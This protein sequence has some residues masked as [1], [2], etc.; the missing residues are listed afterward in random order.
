MEW[1]HV[2]RTGHLSAR[3]IE[4][5]ILGD[6]H[7]NVIHLGERDCSL[8]RNNQ[9]VLEESPSIAIGKRC[10]MKSVLLLFERQSLLAMRMQGPF[11]FL[12]DE[13]SGKF[14]FMEIIHVFR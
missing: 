13:A 9:K 3:H 8:Q 12:L 11:E 5:Q 10:A 1:C 6:E 7:G 4:V 2:H 14:Y